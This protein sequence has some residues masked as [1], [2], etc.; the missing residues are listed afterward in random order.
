MDSEDEA[1]ADSLLDLD[2]PASSPSQSPIAEKKK[3]LSPL[4]R[5]KDTPLFLPST[6]DE[7]APSDHSE[8][9]D[10]PPT[11]TPVA[12][13]NAEAGPGPSTTRHAR[14]AR[15]MSDGV[16]ILGTVGRGPDLIVIDGTSHPCTQ[17][18]ARS[19]R[20]RCRYRGTLVPPTC[21]TRPD[22]GR[23][24]GSAQPSIR[25]RGMAR[26][27]I[28]YLRERLGLS[29]VGVSRL[30]TRAQQEGR[31]RGADQPHASQ[32]TQEVLPSPHP[33]TADGIVSAPASQAAGR[34]TGL[35]P[36]LAYGSLAL[37]IRD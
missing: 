36:A 31:P 27:F 2:S 8:H 16:E 13:S 28:S 5:E 6:Q 4:P 21:W 10:S 25:R 26:V 19:S 33:P 11:P 35:Q 12:I 23:F 1:F 32:Q 15:A 9:A 14:Q 7:N 18:S 29:S 22:V 3:S 37:C 30:P 17:T 20:C 24:F 34:G